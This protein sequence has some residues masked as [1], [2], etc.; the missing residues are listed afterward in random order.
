M[1]YVKF[2]YIVLICNRRAVIVLLVIHMLLIGEDCFNAFA[3]KDEQSFRENHV[4]PEKSVE[5]FLRNV[6]L[7]RAGVALLFVALVLFMIRAQ[8]Y[9]DLFQFPQTQADAESSQKASISENLGPK[10]SASVESLATIKET[11]LDT[12]T[13]WSRFLT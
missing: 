6:I 8:R 2:V 7:I 11:G 9:Y 1:K 13:C 3:Q 10:V 12:G 4:N 5:D